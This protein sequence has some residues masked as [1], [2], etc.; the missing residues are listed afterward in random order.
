MPAYNFLPRFA[1]LVES[2]EKR[3]TIRAV[4]KRRHARSGD[5]LQLY[6]GQRTA[7]CRK[8]ISPDPVCIAAHAVY[9]YKIFTRQEAYYQMCIDG[10]VVFHHEVAGIAIADGF[11]DKT[12]FFEFFE[13]AHGLP[14]HGVLIKW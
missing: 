2:G 13:E 6:T 8:L 3:Q 7:F 5:L 1:P 12:Q 10:E 9:I 4:G 11:A 14:F